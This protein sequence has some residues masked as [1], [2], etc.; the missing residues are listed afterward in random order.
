MIGDFIRDKIMHAVREND[1]AFSLIAEEVTDISIYHFI[2]LFAVCV[3]VTKGS[4]KEI[5]IDFVQ[6]KGITGL[7]IAN[8]IL[9][10]LKNHRID[11]TLCRGNML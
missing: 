10:T 3:N 7:L 11:V 5:F 9:H 4:I 1:S 2:T 8:A 6:S